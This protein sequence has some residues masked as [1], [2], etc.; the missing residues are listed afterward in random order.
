MEDEALIIGT[1]SVSLTGRIYSLRSYSEPSTSHAVTGSLQPRA[2]SGSLLLTWPWRAVLPLLCSHYSWFTSLTGRG[3][4]CDLYTGVQEAVVSC[5]NKQTREPADE[6][7]CVTS[8]RPPQLLKSCNLDPCPASQME[9]HPMVTLLL[10]VTRVVLYDDLNGGPGHPLFKYRMGKLV[11]PSPRQPEKISQQLLWRSMPPMRTAVIK[12][13]AVV[14]LNVAAFA[15]DKLSYLISHQPMSSRQA[16]T[17]SYLVIHNEKM[18]SRAEGDKDKLE[19][20][21]EEQV[22]VD[23]RNCPRQHFDIHKADVSVPVINLTVNKHHE[24]GIITT[25]WLSPVDMNRKQD[26]WSS[27]GQPS[28]EKG[29]LVGTFHLTLTPNPIRVPIQAFQVTSGPICALPLSPFSLPGEV[30]GRHPLQS[31][32]HAK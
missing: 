2:P 29:V 18:F 20:K 12:T 24:Y 31:P 16:V 28:A 3:L 27:W 15:P 11:P 21:R 30:Q 5:L 14:E 4:A 26:S 8:R 22:E 17:S 19:W 32:I 7:L 13:S 10:L 25:S 23:D 6:N 9:A 1:S